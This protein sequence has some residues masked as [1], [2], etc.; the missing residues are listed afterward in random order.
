MKSTKLFAILF[1]ISFSVST[2]TAQQP[3]HPGIQLYK[4]GKYAD[5]V[6]TLSLAVKDKNWKTNAELWNF[7]GLAY[8]NTNDY[9]KA[10][11]ALEKATSLKPDNSIYHTNLSYVHLFLRRTDR[12]TA[13]ATK[14][15]SLDPENV[16]AYHVRS[17]ASLREGQLDGAQKDADQMLLLDATDS[18]GFLLSSQIIMARLQQK[19]S[20]EKEPSLRGN[21]AFL[22]GARDMLRH[23]VELA[24]DDSNK[25]FLKDQL[26]SIEAFCEAFSKEPR[27]PGDQPEPGVTPLKMLAKPRAPYTDLARS[28]NVQGVIRAV[29][30]LGA[31]RRV[32]HV[33]LLTRLGYGLDEEV[34]KAAGAIKFEPRTRDGKPIPTVVT[35]E[36]SFSIY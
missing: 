27:K 3:E 11:K 29:V 30:L 15:I 26:E 12:A 5:A 14:A 23:G 9:K 31:D 7:L 32:H 24:K 2:A 1:L 28:N 36:Y 13:E 10:R 4:Q 6:N 8:V 16:G 35:M 18:R 20:G 21:I 19:L 25:T 22:T 34:V 33:L 17:Q